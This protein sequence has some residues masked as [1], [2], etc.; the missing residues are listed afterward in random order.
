MR[1]ENCSKRLIVRFYLN[2]CILRLYL[3]CTQGAYAIGPTGAKY[4]TRSVDPR[5]VRRSLVRI[6]KVGIGQ[7]IR[8]SVVCSVCPFVG[9][10]VSPFV[11]VPVRTSTDS[12]ISIGGPFE[13]RSVGR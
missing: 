13:D 6:R 3:C 7:S 9:P 1:L 4:V 5:S 12:R 11:R 8:W 2:A 10:S